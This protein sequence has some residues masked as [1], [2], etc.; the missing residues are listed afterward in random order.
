LASDSAN[1]ATGKHQHNGQR[2]HAAN[3]GQCDGGVELSDAGGFGEKAAGFRK[4][5]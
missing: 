2:L 1:S 5:L 4:N 3:P